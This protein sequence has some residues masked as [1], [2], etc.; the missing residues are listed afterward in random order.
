MQISLAAAAVGAAL[1]GLVYT[2]LLTRD[3]PRPRPAGAL[4]SAT[5]IAAAVVALLF[6]A[7]LPVLPPFAPGLPTLGIGILLGGLTGLWALRYPPTVWDEDEGTARAV[8]I[9]AAAALGPALALIVFEGYPNEALM[10]CAVG[11]AAVALASCARIRPAADGDAGALAACRTAESHALLTVCVAAAARLA[12]ERFPRSVTDTA[13]GGYWAL[14]ALLPGVA[15]LALMVIAGGWSARL[16]KRRWWFHAAVASAVSV[17]A[18]LLLRLR[19]PECPWLP[20]VAGAVAALLVAAMPV[21]SPR[22]RPVS[23]AL[24]AALLALALTGAAFRDAQGYGLALAAL[25]ASTVAVVPYLG[26]TADEPR[27]SD[28]LLI[29]AAGLAATMALQRVLI[30]RAG[31]SIVLDYQEYYS[32][33]AAFLGVSAGLAVLAFAGRPATGARTWAAELA[34]VVA[35]LLVAA[36]WATRA[37]AAFVGG[38]ALSGALWMVMSAAV[39]RDSRRLVASAAPLPFAIAS[40]VVAAQFGPIVLQL[41]VTRG[42]RIAA[43][44]V[45]SLLAIAW[46]MLDGFSAPERTEE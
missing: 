32:L 38:L 25:L 21:D 13:A 31:R 11:A 41:D 1:L 24:G 28:A 2:V 17:V 37:T 46:I 15:A 30:E 36:L 33:T 3:R 18:C 40:A 44:A 39:L 19:L 8:G 42:A 29:G 16:G 43:L 4:A 14:P 45:V 23:M 26:R 12:V 6:A 35:P 27:V 9:L 34:A 10:G 7:T 20:C 22:E 5:R